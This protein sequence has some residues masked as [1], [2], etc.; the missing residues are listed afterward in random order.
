MVASTALGS[1]K[2]WADHRP[3]L[4]LSLSVGGG[5]GLCTVGDLGPFSNGTG[6]PLPVPASPVRCADGRAHGQSEWEA[7]GS[8]RSSPRAPP[9]RRGG[10]SVPASPQRFRKV[11]D[12]P[13]CNP[14][15]RELLKND[16]LRISNEYF[17]EMKVPSSSS[18]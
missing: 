14:F 9:A 5:K 10:C 17:A 4:G 13:T 7:A 8:G 6:A 3:S 15:Q 2:P 16:F 11:V 1:V 12:F 18:V